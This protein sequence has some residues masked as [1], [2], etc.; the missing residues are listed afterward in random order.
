MTKEYSNN[1]WQILICPYCRH[2]LERVDT[3]PHVKCHGC[4][5]EYSYENPSG[6]LDLRLKRGKKHKVEFELESPLLSD[7]APDFEP[8]SRKAIPEVDFSHF[9]VPYHLTKEI[10]S[11]TLA[12]H[13]A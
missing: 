12:I 8:L 1:V 2:F 9:D 3:R 11:W 6:S 7:H 4:L 10:L 13:A 5:T